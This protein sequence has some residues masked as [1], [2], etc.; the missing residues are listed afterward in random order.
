M[1]L[2]PCKYLESSRCVVFLL[3]IDLGIKLCSRGLNIELIIKYA[4]KIV[5]MLCLVLSVFI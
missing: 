2:D 3:G 1:F 5:D 4:S